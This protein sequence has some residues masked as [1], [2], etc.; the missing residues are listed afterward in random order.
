MPRIDVVHLRE[1]RLLLAL[2][3]VGVFL[4]VLLAVWFWPVNGGFLDSSAILNQTEYGIF[5]D[6]LRLPG[7]PFLIR[8][9]EVVWPHVF[10]IVL[11]QYSFGVATA[12]MLYWLV[13]N[14]TGSKL[15]AAIPAAYVLL[16]GDHLVVEH[17]ILGEAS[18][19]FFT[20]AALT[21]WVAASCSDRRSLWVLAGA[22]ITVAGTIRFGPIIL[23]AALLATV[24]LTPG[25]VKPRLRRA[26]LMFL[27][28]LPLL[29]MWSIAQ[30]DSVG[31]YVP[32]FQ[33]TGWSLYS[34]VAQ[35][36]DCTKTDI[37]VDLRFLCEDPS[38]IENADVSKRRG[39]A[40]FYLYQGGPAVKRFGAPTET[41][42]PGAA[43]LQRFATAVIIQQPVDYA[44]AVTS[45]MLRYF[46][47]GIGYDRWFSGA[48]ADE[49]D[50]SR[51][52][53]EPELILDQTGEATGIEVPRFDVEE[54]VNMLEDWQRMTR[55][56]GFG[57]LC[58]LMLG[59]VAALRRGPGRREAQ[60]LI[61]AAV[62]YAALPALAQT[63]SYR[64][65][66]PVFYL[67]V[68]A[69]AVAV[70]RLLAYRAAV[71]SASSAEP[72]KVE[73]VVHRPAHL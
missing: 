14:A 15:G 23:V 47:R 48:N 13:W 11:V 24:L 44:R 29:M 21:L 45:D 59:A 37:D 30:G 62:F 56:S 50:I 72:R 7:Y 53:P 5:G 52:A 26:G 39:G 68:A 58:V 61:G 43:V 49:E 38:N 73:R 9:I 28:A 42:A 4:R 6:P 66:I 1:H 18:M 19:N 54:S 25:M 32:G 41:D 31:R 16:A 35:F 67:L 17:S 64:H 20:T 46:D 8:M 36:A 57:L 33:A 63:T 69:A 70:G 34:R 65:S 3:A 12:V 40:G 10:A 2:I 22:T 27:G 55:L 51:R 60:L 71:A